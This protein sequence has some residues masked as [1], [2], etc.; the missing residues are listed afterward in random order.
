MYLK[1]VIMGMKVFAG[2]SI[3]VGCDLFYDL[4]KKQQPI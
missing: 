2:T 1:Q 3:K 4:T